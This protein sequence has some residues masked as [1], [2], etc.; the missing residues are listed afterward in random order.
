MA[1]REKELDLE[2][3]RC[4]LEQ[5]QLALK[6]KELQGEI[7]IRKLEGQERERE[8]AFVLKKMEL[9]LAEIPQRVEQ[10]FDIGKHIRMV[11]PFSEKEVEKYFSHFERVAT[12]LKWPKEV[13]TL[14]LQCVLTGKAQEVYSALSLEQSAVYDTVKTTILHA[15]ELVPE[16]YRQRFRNYFK[17]EKQTF[18]EFARE[19]ENMFDRWCASKQ[20][21]TKEQLRD[22][23]LLEEFKNCV[24]EGL[25]TYLNEQKVSKLCDA[26]TMADEFS[27]T[28]KGL[29][30]N[31]DLKR[32]YYQS[33][34]KSAMAGSSSGS[35]SPS[36]LEA[37]PVRANI[38]C[39]YCKKPGHKISECFV[40]NKKAKSTKPVGLTTACQ[41]P[42]LTGDECFE[43][44]SPKWEN[45]ESS[46][47]S[48]D[49]TPFLTTGVVSLSGQDG[50]VP[51]RILRDTGAAQSL[52]LKGVLL[53]SDQTDTGAQ[54]LVRGVEMG[55]TIVPLHRIVIKS[56][57]VS[58]QV[59]VGVLPSLP[60]E[61]V[62]F[63]LGNDLAGV[64]VIPSP[65]VTEVPMPGESF[66]EL[67]Q[68]FP[69]VFSV[70]AV[71][72]AMSKQTSSSTDEGGT[73]FNLA[74][75]FLGESD[76]KGGDKDVSV[77]SQIMIGK[78]GLETSQD[79]PYKKSLITRET[80]HFR[81]EQ[82]LFFVFS[83]R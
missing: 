12:T 52:L 60:I 83:V 65:Q 55:C 6:E 47:G 73:N 31:R 58:G 3:L 33:R 36:K 2:L 15:Y 77:E 30:G 8:H 24:P 14:L 1:L 62:S 9:E 34:S 74:D 51:V 72:R 11:P 69:D 29:F 45:M 53:L 37:V 10:V 23:I 71:T 40:L 64:K 75:T 5:D 22:L 39:F 25:V 68:S 81:A 59:V 79:I 54:V 70:C 17:G 4:R 61:G 80:T 38:I 82:R 41:L 42:L 44:R 46:D 26:A 32:N 16:A 18:V 57:L 66:D 76:W 13:W 49:Y 27:L 20:V 21:E 67:S 19:K 43:R 48:T 28:H 7:E 50:G 56:P 63:I 35:T 78:E